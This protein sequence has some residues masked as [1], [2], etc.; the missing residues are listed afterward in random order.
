MT[1]G[2]RLFL[3]N[4][5]ITK[6]D[7][8]SLASDI[9]VFSAMEDADSENF[10]KLAKWRLK[11]LLIKRDAYPYKDSWALPG[12]FVKKGETVHETAKRELLE[13]TNV[14]NS[15][16]KLF[17]VFSDRNR[18]PRG[19][20]ISN[21]FM[22]LMDEKKCSLRA[23]TDAWDAA[24]F[25]VDLKKEIES[26]DTSENAANLSIIYNLSLQNESGD[27]KLHSKVKEIREFKNCHEKV[28]FE[29]LEQNGLGFDHGMI[30]IN[31][32]LNLKKETD[33]DLKTA[34]DLMPEYFTLNHLQS[35]FELVLDRKLVTPNFR[36]KIAEFVTET[37]L[38]GEIKGHRPAKLY[39]RNV[40]AFYDIT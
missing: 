3:Q 18:D 1:D 33:R 4:Y 35:V 14:D 30:I 17:E 22:A 36:R 7:R 21:A 37:K 16:L 9:V 10:R 23:G 6:Y 31:A 32:F 34:F 8:P 26:N 25:E 40:Q 38:S 29:I 28:S 2:E 11:V 20:I 39:K 24:W 13:E 15:Y 5:D 19:W 27:V 12:G